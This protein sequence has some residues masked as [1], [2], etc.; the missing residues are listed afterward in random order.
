MSLSRKKAVTTFSDL[1]RS[2]LCL[3]VRLRRRAGLKAEDAVRDVATEIGIK[4]GRAWMIYY[5]YEDR[6]G[7][8]TQEEWL[9]VRGRAA[10]ILLREAA[11]L[12]QQ[13]VELEL[14][15]EQIKRDMSEA[16]PW[17]SGSASACGGSL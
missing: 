13:I 11:E 6:F 5:G 16:G 8:I 12:R 14:E 1:A 4:P 17:L 2:Y 10:E 3:F 9:S 15:A 7:A